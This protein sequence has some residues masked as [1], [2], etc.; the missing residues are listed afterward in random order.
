MRADLR[1]HLE[2]VIEL[3]DE[4]YD[5]ISL[6]FTV[7]KLRKHNFLVQE[8]TPVNYEYFVVKG[9]VKAYYTNQE[10]KEHCSSGYQKH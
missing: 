7:K 10:G 4:E 2:K 1:Q 5:H 6:H 9:L 8:A 3:T